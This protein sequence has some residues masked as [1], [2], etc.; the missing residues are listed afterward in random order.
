MGRRAILSDV[1]ANLEAL[2]AVLTDIGEQNVDQIICL[3]D[4]VGY[5]PNP[6]QCVDLALQFDI[7]LLGNHDLSVMCEP[8]G[9]STS[10]ERWMHWTREQ[11]LNRTTDAESAQRR[12]DFLL[13]LPRFVSQQQLA[14]VHGSPRDP[15]HEYVFPEDIHNA[16]KIDK[17]FG[18][19]RKACFMGHTHV[20]GVFTAQNEY[21]T[22]DEIESRFVFGEP[23]VMINV[24]SVGQP[25]DDD[26]RASYIVLSDESVE[27]HRV[28]YPLETTIEK[29][30]ATQEL[31]NFLGDRLREGR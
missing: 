19:V 15:V 10:A 23:K 20:P 26:P 13:A 17:L 18:L 3:G 12:W 24:G 25:R 14:F 5:G 1:H 9:C 7:C 22:A 30:Y 29:I 6:Q 16:P 8:E 4:L 21:F 11:V 2:T 27:F 28:D 31:D